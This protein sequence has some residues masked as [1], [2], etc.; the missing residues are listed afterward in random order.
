LDKSIKV[1]EWS[2][3]SEVASRKQVEGAHFVVDAMLEV[4]QVVEAAIRVPT[5]TF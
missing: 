5:N 1:K 3:K 2:A 4:P